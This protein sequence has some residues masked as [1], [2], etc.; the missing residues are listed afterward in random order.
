MAGRGRHLLQRP[1]RTLTGKPQRTLKP[2]D[3]PEL[4]E[5]STHLVEHAD[6]SKAEPL[7]QCDRRRIRQ[8]HAGDHRLDVLTSESG[9]VQYRTVTTA[10]SYASASDRRVLFGIGQEKAIRRIDIRWPSGIQQSINH[11]KLDQILEVI[12]QSDSM[13]GNDQD[14]RKGAP[15]TAWHAASG[16]A[17][18]RFSYLPVRLDDKPTPESQYRLGLSLMRQGKLTQAVA[19]L[20]QAIKM[21]PSFVDAHF[22]LGQAYGRLGGEVLPAAVDQFVEALRLNPNHVEARM[23]L[24]SIL[25]QEGDSY[26]AVSELQRVIRYAPRNAG[27]YM[28]L[29]NGQYASRQY[30]EAI[31]AFR[32]VL[33]L[34]PQLPLAHYGI[35]L[36]LLKQQRAAEAAKE[37]ESSVNM[38]PQNALA[39][40]QLGK[41]AL[42]EGDLA[43]AATHLNEAIHLQ[44][45]L[46]ESYDEL[47][48]LYRRQDKIAEAESAY[49]PGAGGPRSEP[50]CERRSHQA[51]AADCL[52]Q[53]LEAQGKKEEA[54]QYFDAVERLQRARGDPNRANALNAEGMKLMDEGQLDNALAHFQ[55][56]LETDPSFFIAAYNQGVVLAH[57]GKNGEAMQAFRTGIRLRPDFVMAHF[58][59]AVVLK[60]VGDPSADEELRKA[61]LLN[62]Y[63]AQ[64]LGR[65]LPKMAVLP[66]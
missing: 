11:P 14:G 58:G 36:A 56:A 32:K 15:P 54:K 31:A 46:A 16:L 43:K 21:D 20:Q 34:N 7:V 66:K 39:N 61:Q 63:V 60:A 30:P 44:P 2:R 62:Q 29:G 65:T 50:A 19:A 40:Y 28:L 42:K 64:P 27:L 26:A 25:L 10:G 33:E 48:K 59:L 57:Q 9:K 41:I 4:A 3:V 8:A 23:A 12:E 38:N 17:N 18:R 5:F 35:G 45:E 52:A 51:N 13:P 55:K 53:L 1:A 49:R 47:A 24:S 37:F 6:G 22:S